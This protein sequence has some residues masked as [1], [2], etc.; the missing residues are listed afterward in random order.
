MLHTLRRF[1]VFA[2]L[3][4]VAC[5][6]GGGGGGP[7]VN[8][9]VPA[10]AG[11][12]T[13]PMPGTWEIRDVALVETNDPAP[14][15]P[16][17]GARVVI[18]SQGLLAIGPF[19]TVRSDLETFLTFPLDWYVNQIDGKTVLYGLSYDR[20]ALGGAKEQV[21]LAGGS[22]N[23]DTIAVE[24]WNSRQENS[25]APERFT[26]SRYTLARVAAA[27]E[28]PPVTTT[29]AAASDA[30]VRWVADQFASQPAR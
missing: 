11:Q 9:Q 22:V 4:L 26:R 25:A 8:A 15:L 19:S 27:L 6:G 12:I 20:L 28:L 7:S 16:V 17:N 1:A 21:G 14:P 2:P 13:I 24:Q 10:G 5:G 23:I 18:G 3:L 29:P 30:T